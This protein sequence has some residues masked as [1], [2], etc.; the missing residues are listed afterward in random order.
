MLAN[1]EIIIGKYLS[2]NATPEETQ[3]LI[4]WFKTDPS[5]E[6]EFEQAKK[7]WEVSANL[8][9]EKDA[10][11]E[12]AWNEFKTLTE[13]LPKTNTRKIVTVW[14]IAAA[15]ALFI[16]M[17]I[18]VKV[19]FLDIAQPAS[20]Q[21]SVVQPIKPVPSVTPSATIAVTQVPDTT[22]IVPI[23]EAKNKTTKRKRP[24]PKTVSMISI[25]TGDS[26]K[27]F[28]LP[29]NSIVFLN[30]HSKL[31]YPENFNKTQRR[32]ALTGEA[33]FEVAKDSNVFI[34]SCQKTVTRGAATA[35]NIKS[36]P[37]D[38]E[39]EVIVVSGQAEFSGIGSKEFKKLVLKKGETGK[40]TKQTGIVEKVKHTRKNYKWW[41]KNNLKARIKRFFDKIKSKMKSN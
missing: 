32:V 9:K 10:D 2:G 5:H 1:K 7:L 30:A 26:V 40:F 14:R 29:D 16:V 28:M 31:E 3:T 15:V 36:S 18:L 41:Q 33:F 17:G 37:T 38:K 4:T 12:F 39:V 22:V 34:V 25:T 13:N 23:A 24:A 35:F 27:I 6:A 11:V 20:T 21:I 8:K 19:F